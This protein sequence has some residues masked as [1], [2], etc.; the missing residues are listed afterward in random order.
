MPTRP[1]QL[2]A[3]TGTLEALCVPGR[4]N[5]DTR[6]GW[7]VGTRFDVGWVT[8]TEPDPAGTSSCSGE[9]HAE[10]A[11]HFDRTEGIW[12]AN[13]RVYFDCA[14]GGA[15][16]L[17]QIWEPDPAARSLRLLYE[18]PTRARWPTPTT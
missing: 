3:G 12:A 7:P 1:G 2:A 6:R 17:G 5:L 18:S 8:I 11:A 16:G 14:E 10:G 15:A 4:P 13:G 9:A